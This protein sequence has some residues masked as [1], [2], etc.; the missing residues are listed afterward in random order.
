MTTFVHK[1]PYSGGR[2][3]ILVWGLHAG[4]ESC[5]VQVFVS[6]LRAACTGC[7]SKV[8]RPGRFFWPLKYLAGY[9]GPILTLQEIKKIILD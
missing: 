9:F 4:V 1:Q 5:G 6:L 2:A 7:D 8:Q 3:A